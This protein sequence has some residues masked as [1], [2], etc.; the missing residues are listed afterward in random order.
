M[1]AILV[2]ACGFLFMIALGYVLKRIGLFSVDDSG[3]LSKIVLKITLPMA[4]RKSP[5]SSSARKLLT[6][7]IGKVI[8]NTNLLRSPLSS[9]ENSPAL[10]NIKPKA[11]MNKNPKALMSIA[12]ITI[13]PMK[14]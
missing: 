14:L 8:F 10:F 2:K 12:S 6:M 5:V 3:V 1:D 4:I 13:P 9:K 7:D 11:I